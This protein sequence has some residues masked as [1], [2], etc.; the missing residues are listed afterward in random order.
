MG[1]GTLFIGYFLLLN[2]TY[3]AFTDLIAALIIALGL[4]KL[5][6]V[7]RN[8]KLGFFASFGLD[9][10]GLL[11]LIE[12]MYT[13]FFPSANTAAFISYISIP[14]YIII[15]MLTIFILKGIESLAEELEITKLRSRAKLLS[16]ISL[17][18]YGILTLLAI[19][20]LESL[21]AV[22]T[23]GVLSI[24]TLLSVF[25]LTIVNLSL[26]Y[27]AYANICMPGEEDNNFKQ[28]K[29]KFDIVNKFREHHEEKNKEYAEYRL[30]KL[31]AKSKK[32]KK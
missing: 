13:M 29:S 27:T 8:F 17:F 7:E 22:S 2:L 26:I 1:F 10:I 11:E 25:A 4:Y 30:E 3:S 23:L 18:I 6:T 16:P 21:F 14:K 24:V 12:K 31:K 19:P 9:A 15:S 20:E 5:T 32:K 28:K